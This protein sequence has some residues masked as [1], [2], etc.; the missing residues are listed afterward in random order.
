MAGHAQQPLPPRRRVVSGAVLA[1]ALLT[2]LGAVLR[3]W[4]LGG[5]SFWFDE[6]V[7]WNLLRRSLRSLLVTGIPGSESTPP[8]YYIVAWAWVR[9]V[10]WSEASLR[11]FSAACGTATIPVAYLAARTLTG[12]RVALLAAAFVAAS[13]I[14]VWYSQEARAYALFVLLSA[15]ALLLFARLLRRY[16]DR[17][18]ALW[19]GVTV[20]ALA[21]HYF[22][23]FLVVVEA[24]WLV[25]RLPR[26]RFVRWLIPPALACCLLAPLAFAQ[27]GHP[28]ALAH[29]T[30]LAGRLA[31]T[32]RWFASGD[33]G[34]TIAWAVSGSAAVLALALLLLRRA[35]EQRVG[36]LTALGVAVAAAVPPIL[37]ALAG[38]DY[39]F[40]RNFAALWLPLAIALA[41]GLIGGRVPWP[42]LVGALALTTVFVVAD[43]A[44]WERPALQRDNYRGLVQTLTRAPRVA[45]V[46]YPGWDTAP[47]THYDP[48]LR[49]PG[50]TMSLRELDFL[51]V[52]SNFGAWQAPRTVRVTVP[53]GFHPAGSRS[54]QHFVVR[55]FVASGSIH[56]H[57]GRLEGVVS[58]SGRRARIPRV[59][60][61]VTPRA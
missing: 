36:G 4:R 50:G 54:F 23:L 22:A 44:V 29:S 10:G 49:A 52:R 14:L 31:E 59:Q 30:A 21:T 12:A 6:V 8:L 56:V 15:V 1:L 38:R 40:F 17:D 57:V 55:R 53:T 9:L 34:S 25:W 46:V 11:S 47:L 26:R 42:G 3:F 27:R 24:A 43:V 19:S 18:A 61:L 13:P 37:L 45:L 28:A 7:T 60:V 16:T 2:A 48:S 20:L 32:G 51:G 39:V 5:Q 41:A 58:G 33:L 35:T